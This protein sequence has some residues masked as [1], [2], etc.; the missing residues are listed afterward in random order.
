MERIMLERLLSTGIALA[1]AIGGGAVAMEAMGLLRTDP[2]VSGQRRIDAI[3]AYIEATFDPRDLPSEAEAEALSPASGD[4]ASLDAKE[5]PKEPKEDNIAVSAPPVGDRQDVTLVKAVSDA[6]AVRVGIAT[7][8][9]I[10][11]KAGREPGQKAEP[12]GER[13][14]L[15]PPPQPKLAAAAEPVAT[16]PVGDATLGAKACGRACIARSAARKRAR[17]TRLSETGTC[18]F[19]AGG[20]MDGA[21]VGLA[22]S[23]PLTLLP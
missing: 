10:E 4:Y 6:W 11:P 5:Q 19:W 2:A 18:P 3:V 15:E 20:Q 16:A 17:L 7:E 1:I 22:A 9:K 23:C 13:S 8:P 12:E 14:G 21:R